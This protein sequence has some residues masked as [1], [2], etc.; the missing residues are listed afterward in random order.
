MK[1]WVSFFKDWSLTKTVVLQ[2]HYLNEIL[3]NTSQNDKLLEIGAGS[4][5][6]SL[7]LS[8]SDRK[9]IVVSDFDPQIL[10]NIKIAMPLITELIDMFNIS[11]QDGSIDCI[12]HQGLMEHFSDNEIVNSLTEQARVAKLIIFDVPNNRRWKK[13]Q[14]YGNERFLSVKKW[15][16]LINKA[17]LQTVKVTGRRFPKIFNY[18]PHFFQNNELIKRTFGTSSIFIC[19]KV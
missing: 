17:D 19:K 18:L 9:N 15:I 8:F 6:S 7:A 2:Q 3:A 14:E 12:Y 11:K 13:I 4:G 5:F 10:E 16:E 1:Q